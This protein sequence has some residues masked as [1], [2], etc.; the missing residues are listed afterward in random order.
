[1]EITFPVFADKTVHSASLMHVDGHALEA[2]Q[3]HLIDLSYEKNVSFQD[4]GYTC[5][6][7]RPPSKHYSA[8]CI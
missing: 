4:R 3:T 1:M 5:A 8:V 2:I 7:L 6:D